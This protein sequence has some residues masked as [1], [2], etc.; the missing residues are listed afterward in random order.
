MTESEKAYYEKRA[1]EYDDWYLGSGLFAGRIR[2]GWQEEVRTLCAMLRSL[3]AQSALDV[4]CG[5]GFL[6][7]HLAGRVMAVDQSPAMLKVARERLPEG[8]VIQGDAFQLPFR[9]RA[10]DCLLAGHFYGHLVKE[11]R[12]RFLAEARRV[13]RQI[14]VVDAAMR[15]DVAPEQTQ[16]RVLN[17]GSRHAVYKR[18]FVP[19]ELATELGGG[20]VLHAGRWFVAVLAVC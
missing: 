3:E 5:T 6:T 4:A 13:S 7:R 2:P 9:D 11:D 1:A 20:R 8:A 17:D 19:S 18:F 12:A 15:D 10:F 16:E 14:V